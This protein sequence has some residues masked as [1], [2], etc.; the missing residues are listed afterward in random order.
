[1][2][3]STSDDVCEVRLKNTVNSQG[4]ARERAG[5]T[6]YRH[7]LQPRPRRRRE[8][9]DSTPTCASRRQRLAAPEAVPTRSCSL[10]GT[11]GGLKTNRSTAPRIRR[12]NGPSRSVK[13][14][15][16]ETFTHKI[17]SL[18]DADLVSFPS[19]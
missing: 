4:L 16:T 15:L 13:I 12:N 7:H 19:T 11:Y 1:M 2:L 3:Q 5:S 6:P 18:F 14:G 9:L 17:G 10:V 8:R